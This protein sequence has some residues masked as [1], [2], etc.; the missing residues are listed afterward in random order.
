MSLLEISCV[1]KRF[2]G[3]QAVDNVSLSVDRGELLGLFGPNG[4]GKTTT[5]NLIA[6]TLM[7]DSGSIFFNGEEIIPL[8]AAR[9]A[10]RGIGRSLGD[11]EFARRDVE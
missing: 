4:A 9:R 3:L 11:A 1:S 5:F 7:P 6:G 2:S 8:H 10:L